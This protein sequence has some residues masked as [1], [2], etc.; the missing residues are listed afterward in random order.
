MRKWLGSI[1]EAA[2]CNSLI[3]RV[4]AWC[5]VY[6][7][8]TGGK[9]EFCLTATNLKHENIFVVHLVPAFDIL[10]VEDLPT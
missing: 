3:T 1:L 10:V 6:E 2:I 4:S 5:C 9:P 7:N 8:V